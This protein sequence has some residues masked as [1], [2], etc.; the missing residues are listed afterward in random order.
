MLSIG[1]VCA[2]VHT[3]LLLNAFFFPV[4]NNIQVSFVFH[5][6]PHINVINL[7]R[8]CANV[9]GQY[10]IIPALRGRPQITQTIPPPKKI[11]FFIKTIHRGKSSEDI[12]FW[13]RNKVSSFISCNLWLICDL[14]AFFLLAPR[15]SRVGTS[16]I[17]FFQLCDPSCPGQ[18]RFFN[19]AP[20]LHEKYKLISMHPELADEAAVP[21]ICTCKHL[22]AGL[23][24]VGIVLL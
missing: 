9:P 22:L 4:A 3:C 18:R 13:F 5:H 23:L 14:C 10:A 17:L 24:F 19:Y 7:L 15:F 20:K 11:F 21:H 6:P 12:P 2:P 16:I 1:R 8:L